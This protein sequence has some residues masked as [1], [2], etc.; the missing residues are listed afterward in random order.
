[1]RARAGVDSQRAPSQHS[2]QVPPPRRCR[3]QSAC[4]WAR[5]VGCFV[6]SGLR[7]RPLSTRAR[8]PLPG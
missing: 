2:R 8:A 6:A 4:A 5:C 3:A 7:A 1:M